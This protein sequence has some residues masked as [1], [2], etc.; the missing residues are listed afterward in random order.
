MMVPVPPLLVEGMNTP[1][2]LWPLPPPLLPSPLPLLAP[3]LPPLP[4]PPPDEPP[5]LPC[6]EVTLDP[7]AAIGPARR[8]PN[9]AA[10]RTVILQVI[11]EFSTKGNL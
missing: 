5:L 7:H 8:S 10:R 9:N 3:P 6:N 1:P 2:L 11:S 4:P